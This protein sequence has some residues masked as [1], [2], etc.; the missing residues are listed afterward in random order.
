MTPVTGSKW[1]LAA[2]ALILGFAAVPALAA[3]FIY[4]DLRAE[5]G[6]HAVT[7]TDPAGTVEL[8]LYAFVLNTNG[9]NADD[10]WAYSTASVKSSDSSVDPAHK[11]LGNLSG[12]AWAAGLDLVLSKWGTSKT[13]DGDTDLDLGYKVTG[14]SWFTATVGTVSNPGQVNT[15]VLF[16]DQ[17]INSY[18]YVGFLLASVN[19]TLT[20]S[21]VLETST[22][23]SYVPRPTTAGTQK[24]Y[25]DAIYKSLRGDDPASVGVLGGV[26]VTYMPEPATMALLALGGAALAMRRR[27]VA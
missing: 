5:D 18:H 25:S 23:V 7:V 1:I 3:P 4:Y 19:F 6:S 27:R 22:V 24:A 15:P 13:L 9:N 26:T 14:D 8:N 16:P 17:M 20:G 10:R 2:V 11:L 21:P 12:G